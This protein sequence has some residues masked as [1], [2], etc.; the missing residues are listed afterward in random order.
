VTDTGCGI[1]AECAEHVFE[2]FFTT[3][4]VEKGCGLGLSTVL[5]IVK[6]GGGAIVIHSKPGQ[7]ASFEV[8]LPVVLAADPTPAWA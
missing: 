2:P 8:L 7:G 5:S 3:K 4:S 1:D 6:Q